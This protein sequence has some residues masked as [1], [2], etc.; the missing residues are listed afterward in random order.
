MKR[1]SGCGDYR[2]Y[3][4]CCEALGVSDAELAVQKMIVCDDI[5]A[6]T[7]RHWRNFGLVR[8]VETLEYRVAPLFDSGSSLWH[9]LP[10]RD[11][12]YSDFS[13]FTKPFAEDANDQLRL[14]SDFSW[15]DLDA[16]NGFPEAAA[17]LLDQNPALA[18][19]VD[20]IFEGI[21]S[22]IERLRVIAS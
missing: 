6:N 13:F 17:D 16:L 2:H 9:Q 8:D 5:I 14:V 18:G 11:M 4:E 15:L 3:I 20:F 10:T 12:A 21:R 7:D 1:R 19:R 22:R